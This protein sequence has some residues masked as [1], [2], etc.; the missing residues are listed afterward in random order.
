MTS[1]DK[2]NW[3]AASQNRP[4][5]AQAIDYRQTGHGT[6]G[7]TNEISAD[8]TPKPLFGQYPAQPALSPSIADRPHT[9]VKKR[10]PLGFGSVSSPSD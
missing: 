1:S 6:H 3:S 4:S 2:Q 9:N 7:G 5:S 8:R 10:S